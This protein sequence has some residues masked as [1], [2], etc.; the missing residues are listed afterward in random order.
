MAD[1]CTPPES[2]QA[3]VLGHFTGPFAVITRVD[4]FNPA[5]VVG[6]LLSQSAPDP[7]RNLQ[8]FFTI[9]T[10]ATGGTLNV[11]HDDQPL[12]VFG[13]LNNDRCA[14]RTDAILVARAFGPLV[15]P[16]DNGRYDLNLDGRVDFADYQIQVARITPTCGPDPYVSRAPLVCKSPGQIVID[17]QSI[18]DGGTTIDACGTCEIIIK[19]S[20][21]VSGQNA[22]TVVGRARITV[23]DSIIVGQNAVVV[24]HDGGVISM[25][26]TIFHGKTDF[27]GSLQLVDRGGNVFE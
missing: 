26:N 16:T 13:D 22:I 10:R 14:D 17:H 12:P 15:R 23:D 8:E 4:L 2:W 19:N 3:R 5:P 25:G 18:E 20:L 24:L 27:Q 11:I 1:T 21:I 7:D 9:L 6:T